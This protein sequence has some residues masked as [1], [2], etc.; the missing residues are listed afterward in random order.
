MRPRYED[1]VLVLACEQSVAKKKVESTRMRD[2]LPVDRYQ[3]PDSSNVKVTS[4]DLRDVVKNDDDI[5]RMPASTDF[6]YCLELILS[7][8][9]KI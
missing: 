9:W 4:D 6:S 1:F 2:F 3:E 7:C 8:Q 5:A